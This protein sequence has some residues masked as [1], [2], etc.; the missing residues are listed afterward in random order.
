MSPKGRHFQSTLSRVSPFQGS[1]SGLLQPRA[2][3]AGLRFWRPFG[4]NCPRY[5]WTLNDKEE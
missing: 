4:P 1:M 5:S 2:H 3:A